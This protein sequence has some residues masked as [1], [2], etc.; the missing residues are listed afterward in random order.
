MSQMRNV[1]YHL[2][3]SAIVLCSEMIEVLRRVRPREAEV[4]KDLVKKVRAAGGGDREGERCL[5]HSAY[6]L[7]I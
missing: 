5:T 1:Y 6:S 3:L 2:D 7:L 4:S